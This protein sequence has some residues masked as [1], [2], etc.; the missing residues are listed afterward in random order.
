MRWRCLLACCV[1]SAASPLGAQEFLDR[2]D[3]KLTWAAFDNELRARMS[4]LL[5]LEYYYFSKS[6]PGLIDA[7]GHDLFNPRLALF[8]DAQLGPK[9]YF[10][11]QA[12]FD[13]HFDPSDR[14]PQAR[15]DEYALRFTPWEDGRL[16]VALGKFAPAFGQWIERHLSWDNPFV[17]APLVYE[18][19]LPIEDFSAPD[20]PY[21]GRREDEKYEYISE[22][23]GPSY[24]SGVAIAGR[25]DRFEYA[26]KVANASLSSR[27]ESWDATRIGFEYPS[28]TARLG[29]RPNESWNFGFS[30]SDGAYF[31]P[32][33]E[34]SL[35]PGKDRGDYHETV[36]A[37]DISYAHGHLQL[38]AE[39]HEVRF[40]IPRLGDGESFG[41][42]LEAK[43]KF[44]P[45][46][47]GAL[48][49]N[50]QFFNEISDGIGG[51]IQFAPDIARLELGL[52]YRI[53]EHMQL[54]LEY[55][56]EDEE[57]G[58]FSHNFAT[59]FTV[60]F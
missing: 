43:Y 5:D 20:L 25:I 59:Q 55:Y 54:K 45:Q 57:G 51:R 8:L 21:H 41:Y 32:D 50:Q 58:D 12:R 26:F 38:W 49:W 22:V 24:S 52:I 37:Q 31:R 60:R 15:L 34:P 30:G 1:A 35:P 10:F 33:A 7:T 42:F 14:G 2:V 13:R 17:S 18:N 36:L 16:S 47:F 3:E 9:F 46:F 27:P 11:A 48:R 4:G 44:T 28:V 39:F 53:T 40:E 6:A 23:W 19:A 29:Y 56:P